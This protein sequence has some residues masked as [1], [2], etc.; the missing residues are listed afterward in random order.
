M[1][2]S[3]SDEIYITVSL[4]EL[5]VPQEIELLRTHLELRQADNLRQVAL[6]IT[7]IQRRH[8]YAPKR[9]CRKVLALILWKVVQS[10]STHPLP[11]YDDSLRLRVPHRLHR[12]D[13]AQSQRRRQL[14]NR[15]FQPRLL[16][17]DDRRQFLKP[18]PQVPARPHQP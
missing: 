14:L 16:L 1:S 12:L 11:S 2:S 15:P 13:H 7:P 3:S 17:L 5:E 9:S 6:A 10:D 18:F 8:R 4:Q